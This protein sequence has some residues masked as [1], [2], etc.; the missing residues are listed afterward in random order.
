MEAGWKI[1]QENPL[2]IGTGSFREESAQTNLVAN[3]RPAHSAWVKTL[4][5]NGILG[6]VFLTIYVSSY[7]LVGIQKH[8]QEQI[9]LGL[10]ITAALA[11]AFFVKEFRGKSLWFLAA[12]GIVFL[13]PEQML[14]Y[15]KL[16]FKTNKAMNFYSRLRK[17]RFGQGK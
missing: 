15:I 4:A 11:A 9:L 12:A 5:E 7:A 17:V 10:F 1:F 3:E 6:A 2:G 8:R 16:G 14:E 13:H